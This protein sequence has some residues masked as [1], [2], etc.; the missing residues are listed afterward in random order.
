MIHQT[1]PLVRVSS[2]W[3]M[4]GA[5]RR[6]RKTK[7]STSP[8]CQPRQETFRIRFQRTLLQEPLAGSPTSPALPCS[9]TVMML[10]GGLR[11]TPAGR[12]ELETARLGRRRATRAPCTNA[13][14]HRLPSTPDRPAPLTLLSSMCAA[15]PRPRTAAAPQRTAPRSHPFRRAPALTTLPHRPRPPPSPAALFV[16]S[17]PP[18]PALSYVGRRAESEWCTLGA[19]VLAGPAAYHG[20]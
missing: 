17:L 8:A 11:Y 7:Q 18:R 14:P 3:P 20:R 16:Y 12:L 2:L 19:V 4:P 6:R 5:L 13:P 9:L 15:S 1:R 10:S